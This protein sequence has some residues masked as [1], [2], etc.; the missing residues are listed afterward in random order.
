MIAVLQPVVWRPRQFDLIW[1][2]RHD[3]VARHLVESGLV[4]ETLTAPSAV[5]LAAMSD[6]AER[7]SRVLPLVSPPV[8]GVLVGGPSR[9]HR[10]GGAE[11]DELAAGLGAFARAHEASLLVTTSRRTPPGTAAAIRQ[12]LPED[13]HFIHDAG[14]GEIPPEGLAPGDVYAGIL[15]LAD[16]IVATNDSVAMMS[17][18]AATAK[19]LYGWRLPGGKARFD[20]F[21]DGLIDH[22]ALRWFDGGLRSWNYPPLDAAGTI[23]DAIKAR[24]DLAIPV[25][26]RI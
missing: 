15:G 18:A 13:R 24:L 25:K 1:A 26:H 3:G 11:A 2:P 6:A 17:E 8:V 20:R 14:A 16:V 5:T 10:F 22:G 19:P 21:Y 4:V 7:L 23:A 9:S 12:A